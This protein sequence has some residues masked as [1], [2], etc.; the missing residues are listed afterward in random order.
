[1]T[2]IAVLFMLI[3]VA[4]S[5]LAAL[6]LP[7]TLFGGIVN[8]EA[9]FQRF[10]RELYPSSRPF[11]QWWYFWVRDEST[12]IHHALYVHSSFCQASLP[13]NQSGVFVM[14]AQVDASQ[15]ATWSRYE[16]YNLSSLD[17]TTKG[18]HVMVG[19]SFRLDASDDGNTIRLSGA[20]SNHAALYRNVGI[21][22]NTPISWNITLH[23]QF[24]WYAQPYEELP[25]RLTGV[26]Q[27]NTYA[28]SSLVEGRISVGDQDYDFS[29]DCAHH[30]AYA[31]MNWGWDFPEAPS[32]SQL[33]AAANL[34]PLNHRSHL[35][36]NYSWG[37]FYAGRPASSTEPEISVIAGCG[38]SYVDPIMKTMYA[39]A[40]PTSHVVLPN[41]IHSS[42]F[43]ASHCA[44]ALLC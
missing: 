36:F 14:A 23:R 10:R 21:D 29:K 43:N 7:G 9:H 34:Q 33:A 16:R 44:V 31:D 25:D 2:R 37:W 12:A 13:C 3:C 38:F 39:C 4:C 35:D 17:A 27:W 6:N 32:S 42:G 18:Q 22:Q 28:H 41:R 26:I 8:P 11:F 30:R 24:G 40:V 19:E 20:L 15:G 5:C 1:M